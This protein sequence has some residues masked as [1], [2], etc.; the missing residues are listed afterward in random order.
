MGSN[1]DL[2]SSKCHFMRLPREIRDEIY[3]LTFL[4]QSPPDRG[5]SFIEPRISSPTAHIVTRS[6]SSSFWGRKPMIRLLRASRT[7]QDEAEAILYSRFTHSWPDYTNKELVQ[8]AL[9]DLRPEA[10]NPIRSV[11]LHMRLHIPRGHS[12]ESLYD[13]TSSI[14][15]KHACEQLGRR[16]PGLKRVQV[17]MNFAISSHPDIN[18]LAYGLAP[19]HVAR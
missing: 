19:W 10:R 4:G 3:Y 6:N 15:W 12:S 13:D 9:R 5:T 7:F 18:A 8:R 16:L 11:Q 17:V 1:Q 14:Q 2:H